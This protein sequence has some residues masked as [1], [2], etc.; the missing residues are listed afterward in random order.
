MVTLTAAIGNRLRELRG[1]IRLRQD[2]VASTA[3]A[4]GLRWSRVAVA[5]LEAGVGQLE[6][7]E[8]LML[9]QVLMMASL[10]ARGQSGL[11]GPERG[12]ELA[13]LLPESGMVALKP[14]CRVA[15]RA[16]RAMVE[17]HSKDVRSTD[18]DVPLLRNLRKRQAA[19]V[20]TMGH[21][22][23]QK[24]ELGEALDSVW[25]AAPATVKAQAVHEAAGEAEQKAARKLGVHPATVALAAQRQWGRSLTAER[26]Q[27]VKERPSGGSLRRVQ[28]VRG[29]VTR[30]LIAE[31]AE[32]IGKRR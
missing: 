18:L 13:D 8:L 21:L 32:L 17:G 27:R 25:A 15:A 24:G 6:A 30:L 7:A 19:A 12:V 31:L 2:D 5:R 23:A 16:L 11:Q 3:R 1:E 4:L 10:R 20:S 29:H 14:D 9:P 28:A 26:D 22:L